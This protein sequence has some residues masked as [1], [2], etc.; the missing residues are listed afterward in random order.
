M[1]SFE[2]RKLNLYSNFIL[3]IGYSVHED[4]TQDDHYFETYFVYIS[5]GAEKIFLFHHKMKNHSLH[6]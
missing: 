1:L 6:F 2:N 5:V 3:S 4:A